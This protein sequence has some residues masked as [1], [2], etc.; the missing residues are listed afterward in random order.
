MQNLSDDQRDADA[1]LLPRYANG[2]ATAA[3]LLTAR[4]APGRP[5][6]GLGVMGRRAGSAGGA[7]AGVTKP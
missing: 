4:L 2:D 5:G 1:E 7:G 6:P 3:R